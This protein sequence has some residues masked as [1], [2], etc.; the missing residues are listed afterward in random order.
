M[1]LKRTRN[2]REKWEKEIEEKIVKKKQK[3]PLIA[4]NRENNNYIFGS[5]TCLTKK[6]NKNRVT[7]FESQII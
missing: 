7:I 1:K 2:Q 3:I 4:S 5:G 6:K